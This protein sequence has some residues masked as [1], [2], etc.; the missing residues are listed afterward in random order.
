MQTTRQAVDTSRTAADALNAN[1]QSLTALVSR[2]R[3]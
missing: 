3:L 1:A 2:L